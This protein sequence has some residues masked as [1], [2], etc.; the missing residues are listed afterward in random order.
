[1]ATINL[2]DPVTGVMTT[3][4]LLQPLIVA[5]PLSLLIKCSRMC[6]TWCDVLRFDPLIGMGEMAELVLLPLFIDEADGD[7]DGNIG[8]K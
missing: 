5:I 4:S 1:M 3:T 8:N 7:D 6:V 2:H